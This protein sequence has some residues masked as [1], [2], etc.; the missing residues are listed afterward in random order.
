M[1]GEGDVGKYCFRLG[2][3]PMTSGI[4][5]RDSLYIHLLKSWFKVRLHTVII[6]KFLFRY[7]IVSPLLNHQGG[8]SDATAHPDIGLV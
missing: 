7:R 3:T 4:V 2:D 5:K 6:K 1:S 8:A